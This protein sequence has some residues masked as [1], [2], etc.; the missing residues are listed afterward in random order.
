MPNDDYM[1]GWQAA[2]EAASEWH[3]SQAK[4]ALVLSGR[5]R[6]PKNLER[7]AEVHKRAAELVLNLSPDE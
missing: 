4:Q 7:E 1:K 3:R 6:F 5:T 2:L